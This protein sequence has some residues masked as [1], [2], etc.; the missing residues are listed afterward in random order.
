MS[1]DTCFVNVQEAKNNLSKLLARA[2]AGE[3]ITICKAGK[4]YA[5][6]I[7]IEQPA[8]RELGF[9]SDLFSESELV[10]MNKALLEPMSE[11]ELAVWY[12]A[13]VI[14]TRQFADRNASDEDVEE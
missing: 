12:D 7:A 1:T 13:S 9:L 8:Q 14:Q 10:E 5:K 6:L 3:E 4:P 11:D 2:H